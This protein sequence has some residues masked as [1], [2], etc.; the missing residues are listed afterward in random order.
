[1]KKHLYFRNP[2]FII[3]VHYRSNERNN[4]IIERLEKVE[5]RLDELAAKIRNNREVEKSN[6]VSAPGFKTGTSK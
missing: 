5:T 4:E 6:A 2:Y 1:M 3:Q